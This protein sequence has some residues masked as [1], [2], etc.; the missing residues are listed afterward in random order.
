MHLRN[1]RGA[2][3]P[4]ASVQPIARCKRGERAAVAAIPRDPDPEIPRSTAEIAVL[5]LHAPT[6]MA[7]FTVPPAV[8]PA[9]QPHIPANVDGPSVAVD[10]LPRLQRERWSLYW[11]ESTGTVTESLDAT[12]VVVPVGSAAAGVPAGPPTVADLLA[13]AASRLGWPPAASLL[14]LDGFKGDWDVAYQAGRRLDPS[15]P[16]VGPLVAPGAAPIVVVRIVL[17][18]EGWK[19]DPALG[20]GA[21]TSS[22]EDEMMAPGGG[23]IH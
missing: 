5:P 11:H 9:P 12:R 2:P 4:T 3:A 22:E 1:A 8:A 21:E 6:T 13:S 15:E 16:L 18:A 17:H 14:R 23:D 20:A 19:L 10:T 7:A